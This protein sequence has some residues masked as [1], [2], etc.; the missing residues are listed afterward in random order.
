M[1]KKYC[2]LIKKNIKLSLKLTERHT[3]AN[4]LASLKGILMVVLPGIVGLLRVRVNGGISM[5]MV[6][7]TSCIGRGRSGLALFH[8]LEVCC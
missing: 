1:L 6:G 2:L 7:M 3:K 4:T 8:H 5:V